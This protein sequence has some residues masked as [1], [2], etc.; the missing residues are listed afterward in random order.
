MAGNIRNTNQLPKKTDE[1]QIAKPKKIDSL[2]AMLKEEEPQKLTKAIEKIVGSYEQIDIYISRITGVSTKVINTTRN[3]HKILK[4][5]IIEEGKEVLETA[6]EELEQ[7]LI[8]KE[9]Q[10]TRDVE[11]KLE[12]R[13]NFAKIQNEDKDKHSSITKEIQKSNS[14]IKENYTTTSNI[15]KKETEK[16][17]TED[18]ISQ[19]IAS[20]N[21][22]LENRD[23]TAIRIL[24]KDNPVEKAQPHFS[25]ESPTN[26]PNS[27]MH[28]SQ[29]NIVDYKKDYKDLALQTKNIIL[30]DIEDAPLGILQ[31]EINDTK[32]Y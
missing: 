4:R 9:N 22:K 6:L 30:E 27:T 32:E 15:V 5:V 1:E 16:S 26:L 28:N 17:N 12:E 31:Q 11:S 25:E 21:Q 29:M 7:E 8:I 13:R 14:S 3:W 10:K 18:I 2:K 19:E 23:K 20:L 24:F